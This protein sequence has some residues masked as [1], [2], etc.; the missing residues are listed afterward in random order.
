MQC[1]EIV[2]LMSFKGTFDPDSCLATAQSLI[3]H[4]SLHLFFLS[5]KITI[6]TMH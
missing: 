4:A 6:H 1:T 3:V 5:I 2:D